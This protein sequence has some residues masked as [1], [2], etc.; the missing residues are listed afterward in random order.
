MKVGQSAPPNCRGPGGEVLA[1][2]GRYNS[3]L[4]TLRALAA[5]TVFFF[6][7]TTWARWGWVG[8]PFFFVLSGYLITSML[9]ANRRAAPHFGGFVGNFFLRRTLRLVPVYALF[10]AGLWCVGRWMP[11]GGILRSDLRYLLSYTFNYAGV[12]HVPRPYYGHFWSL[13]VEWQFYLLWPFAV[14]FLGEKSLRRSV[15]AVIVAAPLVRY[16]TV[17]WLVHEGEP[18]SLAPITTYL[19][20]WTHLDALGFGA[21]LAW[22]EPRR[23]FATRNFLGAAAVVVLGIGLLVGVWGWRDGYWGGRGAF[24][25]LAGEARS[26]GFPYGF[27]HFHEYVWGYTVLAVFF[28]T[29][30]AWAATSREVRGFF[31]WE[32]LRYLGRISYGFYLFHVPAIRLAAKIEQWSGL[33]QVRGASWIGLPFAFGIAFLVAHF[34]Y[35]FWESPFH[36]WRK[37]AKPRLGAVR[38]T[39]GPCVKP[40]APANV[41]NV[42]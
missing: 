3:K 41:T 21:L 38:A 1:A 31:R 13:S 27:V 22:P 17:R 18:H 42:D 20:T 12:D 30:V 36:H 32:W 15:L 34:S 16:L 7:Y 29:V 35:R 37:K 19:F 2:A 6:H 26:L 40:E 10:L 33:T 39:A 25:L 5:T 8:V 4:D 11:H 9:L 14:W 28:A 23:W 24:G